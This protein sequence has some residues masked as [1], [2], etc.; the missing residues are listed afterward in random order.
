MKSVAVIVCLL[1]SPILACG[2]K[3]DAPKPK[4]VE[5]HRSVKPLFAATVAE[6]GSGLFVARGSW[7]GAHQ[8]VV[9]EELKRNPA[10]S[11]QSAT[12]ETGLI[13]VAVSVIAWKLRKRHADAALALPLIATGT[14]LGTGSV[15]FSAGCM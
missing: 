6:F 13:N 12:L 1:L 10:H 4:P 3:P 11:F 8:C 15:L 9:R 14:Q 5:S 7:Y 2:Q